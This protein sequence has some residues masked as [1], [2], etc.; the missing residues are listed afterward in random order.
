M[1]NSN[2]ILALDVGSNSLKL[3]EFAALKSGGIELTKFGVV[4]LG[5]DPQ[6]DVNRAAYVTTAVREL[7]LEHGVKPGP[8]LIS[9]SGQAVFSRFVKLPPVDKEKIHQIILYEAQQ[10]VPFPINEVVWD[11]QLVGGA[12]GEIDVMLAAIKAELIEE[13]TDAVEAT[14]LVADLV[15]V[16]PMTL[17]N[18][19]RYN[20]GQLPGC[21]L[22]V[23]IGARSTDLIFMEGSR[24][25]IRSVPVAGNAI[26]QQIMREFDVSFSEAEEIKKKHAFVSF[27]PAFERPESDV[28][29]RVSKSVRTV[30]TRMHA[31]INRSINFYRSQQG[32]TSPSLVLLT[33]GSSIVAHTDTF[34]KEKL[35]VDVDY[36]NPFLN[37]A[38]SDAITS[39]EIAANAHELGDVVG[40]GLRRVLT[41]PIEINLMP[42]KVV[43]ERNFQKKQPLLVL[44]ALLL[45][46]TLAT[47][48]AYYF[49]M[50]RLTEAQLGNISTE[51]QTL[52]AYARQLRTLGRDVESAQEDIDSILALGRERQAWVSILNEVHAALPDGMFLTSLV[53]MQSAAPAGSTREAGPPGGPGA[54][55]GE[56]VIGSIELTGLAYVDKVRDS[57]PI[58]AF[59]DALRASEF[60]DDSDDTRIA[61]A[62]VP[63]P[64]SFTREYK[65]I[66]HLA[67]PLAP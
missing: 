15:D 1:L 58:I 26:T 11:Y 64:E 45:V 41:C 30:M 47:W 6:D 10:N 13:L 16:A 24:V 29:D 39:E 57:G 65:L 49:K 36:L 48:S 32:G 62:P 27:G 25:F 22:V 33:G 50:G 2:R 14:G 40:L 23:D 12:E 54:A 19:V 21:T 60:F 46:L 52:D 8:V 35:K 34:L 55:S 17:Y 9:V 51:L 43:A 53:P 38:V 31:E 28:A 20:Y 42:P 67:T 18:T 7:L 63:G 3:A 4:S 61:L 59:R 37:V 66:V 5:L 44:A 56:T